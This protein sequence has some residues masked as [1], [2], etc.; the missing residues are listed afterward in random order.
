MSIVSSCREHWNVS[1]LSVNDLTYRELDLRICQMVAWLQAQGMRKGS[2]LVLQLPRSEEQLIVVLA[3]LDLG[4][5]VLPLNDRYT[6]EEIHYYLQ[7]IEPQLSILLQRCPQWTGN[8]ITLEQ[9]QQRSLHD[10]VRVTHSLEP[11]DIAL[12]LY[13]SG[14]TGQ[15][16]GAMISHRNLESTLNG[17]REMW[18]WR[19]TDHLLHVLPMFHVHGLVVALL[20]ALWV[21][22]RVR[23]M[24]RFSAPE[25]LRMLTD[26]ALGIS[27][28]MA[29]PTIWNRL[30]RCSL[31]EHNELSHLR[32][33]TSGSAPMTVE[34]HAELSATFGISIVERYGMTEVG[35]VLSNPVGG[36]CIP[37]TVGFAVGAAQFDVRDA[38]R[39]SVEDGVVGE[40][41]IR[42]PSVISGY[43][44]KPLQSAETI[45]DGWLRSGDLAIRDSDGRFS[46]VG[47]CKE[48]II[49]GGMNVSP[50]EVERSI[51]ELPGVRDAAVIGLPD[52][53]WGERV[54]A[55]VVGDAECEDAIRSQLRDVLA[56]YKQPKAYYWRAE[57]PRNA[58]GKLQRRLARE[59]IMS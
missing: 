34:Q 7:D 39:R 30:L 25:T 2:R 22:A 48:L 19:S 28:F 37:G 58:M 49:S 56:P 23:L 26:K 42:G 53:E 38:E 8:V 33:C 35:I 9:F 31:S 1:S 15:P 3:A 4:C 45:I 5:P 24:D 18:Q 27:V 14:T 11:D 54:V 41:W 46:I 44:R 50:L 36:V 13:T 32:L 12:F 29:V 51:L 59:E 52:P 57:L 16:K 10:P 21:G 40:L 55:V 17:L 20:G 47:R 43:W 6:A